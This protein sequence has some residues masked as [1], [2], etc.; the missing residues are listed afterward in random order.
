MSRK[1]QCMYE[2]LCRWIQ[3]E[4]FIS[5]HICRKD[6]HDYIDKL[7]YNEEKH[8]YLETNLSQKSQCMYEI[9]C[10]WIEKE[11]LHFETNLSQ[12][13]AWSYWE[14]KVQWGRERWSRDEFVTKISIHEILCLLNWKIE[15]VFR[16]KFVTKTMTFQKHDWCISAGSMK[17]SN[18]A[19]RQNCH[20]NS[21]ISIHVFS[22]SVCVKNSR[23]C[24]RVLWQ[25]LS[26]N[27]VFKN[28]ISRKYS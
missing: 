15:I 28:V 7:K 5:R 18:S 12:R 6:W 16:D 3:K 24:K 20:K 4:K 17:T 14:I 2:I 9:L 11:K 23:K 8:V 26:R 19:L 27:K 1:S 10:R 13:L 21:N 22:I 25:I